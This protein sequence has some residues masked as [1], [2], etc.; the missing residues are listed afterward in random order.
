VQAFLGRQLVFTDIPRTINYVMDHC[1]VQGA[2]SLDAVLGADA[3][4]RE[5]ATGYIKS[6]SG[7]V[8]GT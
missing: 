1:D 2:G 6:A 5:W 7:R 3:R 4:A 8:V